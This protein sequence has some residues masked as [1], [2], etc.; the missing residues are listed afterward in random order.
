MLVREVADPRLAGISITDVKVD[1]E[2][3]YADI[4]VSAVE[5]HERRQDV[6]RAATCQRFPPDALAERVD[7]RVFPRLRFHWDPTPERADHIE[8]MLAELRSGSESS[9]WRR[10]QKAGHGGSA[11]EDEPGGLVGDTL[12][13]R[14]HSA[15][16]ARPPRRR[17]IGALLGLGL[18]LQ[19]GK[20][21]QMVLADGVPADLRFLAGSSRWARAHRYGGL[22][23][24]LDSS[25]LE[26]TGGVEATPR[27]EHRPSHHQPEFCARQPGGTRDGGHRAI[28]AECLA[29]WG[30]PITQR[31]NGLAHRDCGRHAGFPYLEHDPRVLRLAAD[32]MEGRR[33]AQSYDLALVR[34]VPLM[35]PVCGAR[36]ERLQRKGLL[37]GPLSRDRQRRITRVMTM[38]T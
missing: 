2:L 34:Q 7:L 37:C 15:G 23:V 4:Y 36:F 33:P 14:K 3:A 27:T 18:A 31:G 22:R 10:R 16:I 25:D 20:Q 21:V 26:R 32:L 19:A 9:R 35:P 1:R 28:L 13:S 30:F 29:E 38:P 24:V 8:R 6:R 12:H 11:N 5:G 17:R